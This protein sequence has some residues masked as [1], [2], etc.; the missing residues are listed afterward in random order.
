ME[1][2]LAR[3]NMSF[4]ADATVQLDAPPPP[5]PPAAPSLALSRPEVL[6]RRRPESEMISGPPSP[7]AV[8]G[9]RV[10]TSDAILD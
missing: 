8:P 9:D 3:P 4:A 5:P 7:A 2:L 6:F 10:D 1:R